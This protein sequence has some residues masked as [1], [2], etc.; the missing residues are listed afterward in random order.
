ML[1]FS[2]ANSGADGQ[3]ATLAYLR[4]LAHHPATARR[5]AT[6]LATYFVSDSPSDGLV[7]TSPA[8]T[9]ARAPTSAQS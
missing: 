9:R 7:D 8:S 6:K 4:Y 1:D 2:H 5:I 3:A